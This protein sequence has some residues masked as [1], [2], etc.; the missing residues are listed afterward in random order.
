MNSAQRP[1]AEDL[2]NT[3]R[4][5]LDVTGNFNVITHYDEKGIRSSYPQRVDTR[6]KKGR[7]GNPKGRPKGSL[8]TATLL[9]EMFNAS[10]PV[11]EGDKRQFMTRAAAMIRGTA[12]NGI[13]GDARSL[14]RSW[15]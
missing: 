11:R 6:F 5:T 4:E 1:D 14:T 15:I 9:K 12:R 13:R 3:I 10:V 8:S 2:R 7:S